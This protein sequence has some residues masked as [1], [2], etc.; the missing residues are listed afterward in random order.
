MKKLYELAIIFAVLIS[1]IYPVSA[2]IPDTLWTKTCGTTLTND[3]ANSIEQTIDGGFIIGCGGFTTIMKT[4]TRGDT[5]W[6]HNYGITA[7]RARQTFDG[8]YII[9]SFEPSMLIKTDQSGDSLWAQAYEM[10]ITDVQQTADSGYIVAGSIGV[11]GFMH[12]CLAKI[13]SLG[14]VIWQYPYVIGEVSHIASVQQTSDGGFIGVGPSHSEAGCWDY[15]MVKTDAN[16]DTLWTRVHGRPLD[17]DEGYAVCQ[18]DDGGYIMTGLYFWTVKTDAAGDT[19]W[20]RYYGYGEI[21]C[22]YSVEQT[23]DGGYL[24][25]GT[26]NPSGPDEGEFY[27]V[28]TDS[29]GFSDWEL[30]Y[31]SE[32]GSHDRG[33]CAI[34]TRH[35]DY[36]MAGKTRA[37]GAEDFDFDVWIIK[38]GSQP[39][40]YLYLPGDANMWAGQWPPRVIGSDL[41]YLVNALR[42]NVPFCLLDGFYAA[43][44]VNGDCMLIG[45]DVIRYVTYFRGLAQLSYC[46]DFPPA[47]LTPDDCPEQPPVFWPTCE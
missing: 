32:N 12:S 4:D 1:L 16:G 30:P 31:G 2:Q 39:E 18:T 42:G 43:A 17:P 22:A 3:V 14:N 9:A 23:G 13:D 37:P 27:I 8:G 45:A 6:T 40:E 15:F 28:K 36:I 19:L 38:I 33:Y 10:L 34:Q 24:V 7:S 44:D 26:I 35:G 46:A 25:A 41:T 47:W 20:S 21:G 11:E 29:L 5:I